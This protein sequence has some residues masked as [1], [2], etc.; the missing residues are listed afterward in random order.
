M[1]KFGVNIEMWV[2]YVVEYRLLAKVL[3]VTTAVNE[4]PNLRY[5]G[6]YDCATQA[7][8]GGSR[9]AGGCGLYSG[10]AQMRAAE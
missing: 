5:A 6:G 2:D 8:A 3:S 4:L 10:L 1:E 9:G 7:A